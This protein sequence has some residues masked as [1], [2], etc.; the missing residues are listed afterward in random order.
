MGGKIKL[1]ARVLHRR[2]AEKP[3]APAQLEGEPAQS[4]SCE[5]EGSHGPSWAALTA[6]LAL[7]A[8]VGVTG[9]I[10]YLMTR[11]TSGT[12]PLALGAPQM[13]N[14]NIYTGQVGQVGQTTALD[15]I[16]T[17]LAAGNAHATRTPTTALMQSMRLPWLGDSRPQAQAAHVATSLQNPYEVVVRVVAPPGGLAALSLDQGG[18]NDQPLIAPGM[19]SVPMRNGVII[20]PAGE[21]QRILM[22]PRQSLYARGNM[23]P[24]NPTGPVIISVTAT[25]NYD[26][27]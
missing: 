9:V 6:G 11:R 12:Q 19:S 3:D 10:V 18:L 26:A 23:S 27:R 5:S 15:R 17:S 7:L 21:A 8:V 2:R 4:A 24:D 1:K 22:N 16:E 20:I 25:D 13:P 14:I